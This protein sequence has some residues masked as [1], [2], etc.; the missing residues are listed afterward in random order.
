MPRGRRAQRF[1]ADPS[2][3][4]ED[5]AFQR[6][7]LE[8]RGVYS[9]L[10]YAGWRQ[11]FPGRFVGDDRVLA[12]QAFCTPEEWARTKAEVSTGFKVDIDTGDWLLPLMV[13]TYEAQQKMVDKWRKDKQRQR[14][15]SVD[16]AVDKAVESTSCPPVGSGSGSGSGN[17]TEKEKEN[18]PTPVVSRSRARREVCHFLRE[19]NQPPPPG[20]EPDTW[21]AWFQFRGEIKKPL[22][23][24]S[25][26]M[27]ARELTDFYEQG[28]DPDQIIRKS[29]ANRWQGLF[30]PK[31]ELNGHGPK[32]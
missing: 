26:R 23:E 31:E 1:L 3:L 12:Q 17:G 16:N 4:L 29:I 20:V 13:S 8:A 30:I 19:P 5:P 6:M 7:G 14:K 22:T 11:K 9:T 32:K 21:S 2:A 25:A 28:H 27:C 18:T 24:L 15:G 10:V